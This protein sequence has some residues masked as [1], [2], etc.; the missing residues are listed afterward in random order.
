MGTS[1]MYK[2]W[3]ALLEKQGLTHILLWILK[4][5][6]TSVGW[7]PE[8]YIHQFYADTSCRLEDLPSGP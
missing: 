1:K 6:H 4:Y 7:L 8:T 3:E 2:T 5:G